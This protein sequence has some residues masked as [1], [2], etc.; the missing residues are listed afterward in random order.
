MD[1]RC[2]RLEIEDEIRAILQRPISSKGLRFKIKEVFSYRGIDRSDFIITVHTQ[3][4]VDKA[5]GYPFKVT[6][7][8]IFIT[9]R[10]ERMEDK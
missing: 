7:K 6:S 9:V 5:Y 10:I 1:Y 3:A 2:P 4:K 8:P